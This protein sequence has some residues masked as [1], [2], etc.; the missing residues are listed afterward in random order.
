MNIP[1]ILPDV[2]HW[3]GPINYHTMLLAGAKGLIIKCTQGVS[4]FDSRFTVNWAGAL[5]EGIPRGAYH[6]YEPE[7][8]PITQAEWFWNH[9]HELGELPL[10]LDVED[11]YAIPGDYADRLHSCLERLTI[12]SGAKPGI[13]TR[14][15]Y[16][17]VYLSKAMGWADFYQL[18]I[19]HYKETAG[20]TVC[21]PWTPQSWQLWQ[22]TSHGTGPKYG[23]T[24]LN[25]DLNAING[26]LPE[27]LHVIGAEAMPGLAAAGVP[28]AVAPEVPLLLAEKAT[29]SDRLTEFRWRY[30]K[31]PRKD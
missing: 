14:A 19:A 10:W 5:Q 16:W 30:R 31:N 11:S 17:K 21:L 6:W 12:L 29:L 23:T 20:P 7:M 18:W 3:Q 4:I 27:I 8:N 9:V 22:F 2:S 13:Y 15:S 28:A 1:W 24:S 25:I 26:E